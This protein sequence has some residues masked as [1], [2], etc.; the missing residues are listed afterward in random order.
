MKSFQYCR[1]SSLVQKVLHVP[2]LYTGMH[3]AVVLSDSLP[4]CRAVFAM[5]IGGWA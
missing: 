2:A 3:A 4:A 5:L 1:Y